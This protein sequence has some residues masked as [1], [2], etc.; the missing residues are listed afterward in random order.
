M[1]HRERVAEALSH[2]K[3]DRCPWQA[4][5]TPEFA[6]RLRSSCT[7]V[8]L[9]GAHN[10]HGG[11]NPYD[12]EMAFDQDILITSVGWANSYYG[13]GDEYVDEWGVGWRSVAYTTPYGVGHYTE[14]RVH[15]LADA[16]AL[17]ALPA[18]DPGRPE[19]YADAQR[20]IAEHGD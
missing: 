12:L 11:G 1:T 19:L 10:P 5:F 4:T 2:V 9:P 15:P 18:P 14:P 3:P 6:R 17:A 8:G 16:E 13:Q 7:W 20:L